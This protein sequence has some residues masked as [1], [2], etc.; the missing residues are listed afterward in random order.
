[1]SDFLSLSVKIL[2]RS[3][4]VWTKGGN[5]LADACHRF[6]NRLVFY[7]NLHSVECGDGYRLAFQRM[8]GKR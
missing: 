7:L 1:M 4:R 2:T 8:W 3:C 5:S 6:Q